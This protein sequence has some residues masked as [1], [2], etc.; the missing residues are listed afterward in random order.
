M[1]FSKTLHTLISTDQPRRTHP[2]MTEIM[3]IRGI[4]LKQTNKANNQN[5]RAQWL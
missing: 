5:L 3:L 1:S 2:D 4:E